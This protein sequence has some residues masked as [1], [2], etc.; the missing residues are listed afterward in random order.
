MRRKLCSILALALTLGMTAPAAA[1]NTPQPIDLTYAAEKAVNS[2]VYIKVTTNA[3]SQLI[4]YY[5]PF[6]DF[7]G[8]FFGRRGD[9]NSQQRRVTPK[10]VGA[11]SG[12]ILSSDGYIVTNNHVVEDATNYRSN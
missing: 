3:K 9:G 5:D 2:V 7:F 6:E 12:V 8:D 4:E 1:Q 10:R 11:G